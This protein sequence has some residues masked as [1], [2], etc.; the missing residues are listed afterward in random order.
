[1]DNPTPELDRPLKLPFCLKICGVKHHETLESVSN[2]GAD[3]VGLNFFQPSVRSVD[4]TSAHAESLSCEAKK[5]GLAAVG[6]F[7]QQTAEDIVKIASQLKLDCIQIHGNEPPEIISQIRSHLSL[8]IVRA[9]KLPVGSL[10]TKDIVHRVAP[11]HDLGCVLLLDADGGAQHGGSGKQLDWNTISEWSQQS[12][13]PWI[14]AGGL[15]PDN[16]AQAIKV[17]DAS[18]VDVASGVEVGK[19]CKSKER[20]QAFCKNALEALAKQA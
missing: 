16:V 6:L 20:I 3:A 9:I 2:S 5:L 18:A 19:G 1:M 8:P 4:P 13:V 17:A 11:W 15:N 12:G 14:L 7:V 10:S